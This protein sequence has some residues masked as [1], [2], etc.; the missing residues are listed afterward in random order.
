MRVEELWHGTKYEKMDFRIQIIFR[1]WGSG[2]RKPLFAKGLGLR[3]L[4]RAQGFLFDL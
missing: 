3:P 1:A 4:R 2:F